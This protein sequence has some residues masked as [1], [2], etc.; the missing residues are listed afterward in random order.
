MQEQRYGI[1]QPVVLLLYGKTLHSMICTKTVL[2]LL[3][4]QLEAL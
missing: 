2:V 4:L 1:I 3:E